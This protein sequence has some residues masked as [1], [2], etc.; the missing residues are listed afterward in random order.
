MLVQ[1]YVHD[2]AFVRYDIEK[3][4]R[5][6]WADSVVVNGQGHDPATGTGSYF[7]TT[8]TKGKKH[9]FRL[10]NGSAGTHYVFSIDGHNFTVIE[11]DLVPIQPYTTTSLNI[12]IGEFKSSRSLVAAHRCYW[13]M[14]ES[15]KSALTKNTLQASDT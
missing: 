10:V 2:S 12:G 4:G 14:G 7:N 3:Q 1:D 9:V 11:S 13:R 8:V 5:A 15:Y 6:A